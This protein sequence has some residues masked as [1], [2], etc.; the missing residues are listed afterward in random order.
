M[1]QNA[2]YFNEEFENIALD[3]LRQYDNSRNAHSVDVSTMD[4]II[5]GNFTTEEIECGIDTLTSNKSP[6]NDCIPAEFIK[7]CSNVLCKTIA[8]VFNYMIKQRY[9]PD[10]WSGGIRSA[11][12]KSGKRNVVD[13]FRGIAILPV[14]ENVFEAVV[15][16]RLEFV[17]DAFASHDKYNNEFLEGNRTSDNVFVL[18]GLVEKQLTINTRLYVC[19]I[20]FSKAFG[21][22]NRTILFYKLLSSGWT[23]RVIDTFRSLY[24]KTH[25]QVKRNGRLS[26]ATQYNLDVNQGGIICG[27]MFRK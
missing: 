6:G 13:N 16:R 7:V 27:L 8:T 10:A 22:V 17:N 5:N 12:F 23:G 18:N 15:Y 1:L 4:E 21:M 20:D 9:F 25:F 11:V 2:D 24:G 14:M 26:R 19:Y 3:F